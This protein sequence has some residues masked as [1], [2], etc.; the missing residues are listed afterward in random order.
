MRIL[1][2]A[3][4]HGYYEKA[5]EQLKKINTS[6]FDLMV[7]P[8]D[9]TDMF[10]LPPG[11]AQIDVADLLTQKLLAFHLPMFCIPGNHDPY[12]IIDVFNEY[13]VNLHDKV[14]VFKGTKFMGFGGAATPFNTIFEPSEEDIKKSLDGLG[15]EVKNNNFVLVV[16]NPPKNTRIDVV[17]NGDHVG[18]D[19]IRKF[20]ED[21]QPLLTI[22]AHIHESPGIDKIGETTIFYPGPFYEG[23]YGVVEIKGKGIKCEIM[24]V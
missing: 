16:H 23:K 12:E 24:T 20:V 2:I 22:S 10:N 13:E 21:R 4:I 1:V 5:F 3:D 15:K 9:L 8:G 18:S 7:C 14:K 6:K 11:F 17:T 19:V